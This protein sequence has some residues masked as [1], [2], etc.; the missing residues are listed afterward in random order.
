MSDF[1]LLSIGL[2]GILAAGTIFLKRF[3]LS[4]AL[5]LLLIAAGQFARVSL[6]N[7]IEIIN[8]L[9]GIEG[10]LL[11][12]DLILPLIIIG[13]LSYKLLAKRTFPQ[14][15]LI[16][17]FFLFSAIAFFSLVHSLLLFSPS[18]I[19][20]GLFYF[21][22]L[23]EYFFLYWFSL[24]VLNSDYS[25]KTFWLLIAISL[26]LAI[27]G[28]IQLKLLP[29]LENLQDFGW[30]PHQ[31]R[32]FSSW[33]DPNFLGGFFAF[34]IT[35]L[36]SLFLCAKNGKEK[37]FA[38]FSSTLLLAALWLT[39]SR[40]SYLALAA[41]IFVVGILKSQ[42]ILITALCAAIFLIPL[43]QRA[44]QRISD[45]YFSAKSVFTD[46]IENPDA[47][48]RLRIESW[49]KAVSLI[50]KHPIL[51]VGFNNYKIAQLKYGLLQDP[52]A[53]SSTG[54][55]STMLAIWATTGLFGLISFLWIFIKALKISFQKFKKS[56]LPFTRSLGLGVFAG[57]LGLLIHSL[58]INSLLFPH[59]LPVYL[60]SLAILEKSGD[61]ASQKSPEP[62]CEHT[63]TKAFPQK[64]VS[65]LLERV[66]I[67]FQKH[68]S[69]SADT[70]SRDI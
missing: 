25:R 31:N 39:Y 43:S 40:A 19:I 11:L 16:K 34:T 48:A 69:L 46:S 41:G 49:Q 14:G 70:F 61:S 68:I 15:A 27:G 35:I 50:K 62:H 6:Q 4:L 21:I 8:P 13:W 30:D 65:G 38:F 7:G 29:D 64:E 26:A 58:F 59:I 67:N 24:D 53:H 52:S 32:L 1:Y 51:G 54:S 33:F 60:L 22:R 42:K 9:K 2:V 56:T 57:T 18:E 66:P 28:F 47:T 44:Q 37:A 12:T 17:P 63:R 5:F 55:D 45:L 23:L 36:G 10:S 3:R 20:N